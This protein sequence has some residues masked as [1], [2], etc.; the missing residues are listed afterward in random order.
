MKLRASNWLA[1]FVVKISKRIPDIPDSINGIL[2]VKDDAEEDI[3]GID[4]LFDQLLSDSRI[5][6][7]VRIIIISRPDKDW[8]SESGHYNAIKT[9][10]FEEG[11][12]SVENGAALFEAC[13][14]RLSR[15]FSLPELPI[16]RQDV[17][18]WMERGNSLHQLPLYILAASVYSVLNGKVSLEMAGKEILEALS[19]LESNKIN[20]IGIHQKLGF[21]R[22]TT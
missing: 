21:H 7:K 2:V 13:V 4:L 15:I 1:G 16:L 5:T 6:C 17:V 20:K 14:E 12:L 8:L 9:F 3:E 10:K 18:E 19:T 22:C 11:R